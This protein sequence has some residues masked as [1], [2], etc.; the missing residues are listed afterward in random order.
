MNSRYVIGLV[1]IIALGGAAYY[2]GYMSG[3]GLSAGGN[4]ATTTPTGQPSATNGEPKEETTSSTVVA[5]VGY[6]CKEKK[7]VHATYFK[8]KVIIELSD[9]RSAQL[10]QVVSASG[11]RYANS[12]GSLVFWSKGPTAFVEEAGKVVYADCVELDTAGV[13]M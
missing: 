3:G 7:T 8:E 11:V 2:F 6:L 5:D 9:G 4:S 1:I 13:E 10:P 12:D